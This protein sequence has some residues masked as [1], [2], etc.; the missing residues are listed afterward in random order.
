MRAGQHMK[1]GV[2][3]C[4]V[5]PRFENVGKIEDHDVIISL[6]LWQRRP[7]LAVREIQQM[8]AS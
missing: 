2:F 8:D 6:T 3:E 1:R 7:G 4:V 5:A